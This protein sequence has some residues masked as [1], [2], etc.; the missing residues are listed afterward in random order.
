MKRIKDEMDVAAMGKQGA[1]LCWGI[2][3]FF[4]GTARWTVDASLDGHC[5]SAAGIWAFGGAWSAGLLGKHL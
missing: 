4:F 3:C 1:S 5:F 2:I